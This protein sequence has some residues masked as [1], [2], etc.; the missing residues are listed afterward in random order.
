MG[1]I[2]DTAVKLDSMISSNAAPADIAQLLDSLRQENGNSIAT[3]AILSKKG[4]ALLQ[5]EMLRQ[6]PEE[7]APVLGQFILKLPCVPENATYP[8]GQK[9]IALANALQDFSIA[10]TVRIHLW[11][12]LVMDGYIIP[13][14]SNARNW[15][16]PLPLYDHPAVRNWYCKTKQD[17]WEDVQC[18]DPILFGNDI[19]KLF[20]TPSEKNALE[21][22]EKDSPSALLMPMSIEGKNLSAKYS[23]AVMTKGAIKIATYLYCNETKF[24]KCFSPRQLLFYVCANWN[25]DDT[26][27]FVAMLEKD[28]PGL[29]RQTLDVFGHDALWYTLYQRDR[30]SR[31]TKAARRAMDPLD[32]TLI[33]YGC[34]PNRENSL[35]LSYNDLTVYE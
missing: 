5:P 32:R 7:Y 4:L 22:I 27:P 11:R 24:L 28:N 31:A 21:A 12:T 25:N 20:K 23:L 35:G 10:K 15:T 18:S 17:G 2:N 14:Y 19:E 26:I 6:W 16:V 34:D 8:C 9:E 13:C 3:L 30:F 33:E 1:N 29:V